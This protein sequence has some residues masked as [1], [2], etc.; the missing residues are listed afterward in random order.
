MNVSLRQAGVSP[1]RIQSSAIDEERQESSEEI[2]ANKA[3]PIVRLQRFF[4]DKS[5]SP[6]LVRDLPSIFRDAALESASSIKRQGLEDM[7]AQA[8]MED[9]SSSSTS[10]LDLRVAFA[11]KENKPHLLS[12]STTSDVALAAGSQAA[13]FLNVRRQHL[14]R[15]FG[16]VPE[17]AEDE[18]KCVS[19]FF[20]VVT[21]SSFSQ[22]PECR[23]LSH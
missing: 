16:R 23:N 5:V 18:S 13:Q 7:A 22:T 10:V 20:L 21:F 6:A 14:A 11:R 19:N 3:D 4:G 1:P 9:S 8:N 12:L 17:V 15:F 2:G